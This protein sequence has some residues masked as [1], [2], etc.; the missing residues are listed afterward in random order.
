M[1]NRQSILCTSDHTD[2]ALPTY[3]AYHGTIGIS[4]TLNYA[5]ANS[6]TSY[7]RWVSAKPP[8]N[9]MW[10]SISK[11]QRCTVLRHSDIKF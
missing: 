6:K 3:E 4:Q 5:A 2:P 1:A 9:D 8:G 7:Y 10:L 11:Y